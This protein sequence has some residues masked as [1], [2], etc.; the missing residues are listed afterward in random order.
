[1]TPHFVGE[2][3]GTAVLT[4][5]GCGVVAGV[6]LKKSKAENGGWVV[7]TAGWAFAV[8]CGIFTAKAFGAAGALNPVGPLADLV[9]Q[10]IPTG[11]GLEMI[12]GEFLGAFTGA[13]LVWLVYLMHW[14]ETPD[15]AMKLGVFATIPAIRNPVANLLTEVIATFAL[16]FVGSSIGKAFEKTAVLPLEPG[17]VGMLIWGLGLSLGGPTGYALNPARDLGPRIAHAVLPI[18]GKGGSDWG[19][20]WVP[21]VGPIVGGV[22]GALAFTALQ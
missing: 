12:A 3:L 18:P 15:Q 2:F 14:Q 17:F 7:V 5:L 10:K 1:M 19:Y 4:L 8:A 20:A 9:Q 6:L 21:I 16:V 13:V 22:L 11:Q